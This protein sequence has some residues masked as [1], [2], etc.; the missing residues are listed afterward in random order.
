MIPKPKEAKFP[1]LYAFVA[2]PR[3]SGMWTDWDFENW[4]FASVKVSGA[5]KD[6]LV[7]SELCGQTD[8]CMF[9]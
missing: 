4:N 1:G 8:G 2:L 7:Y 3:V 9:C 5:P 6:S